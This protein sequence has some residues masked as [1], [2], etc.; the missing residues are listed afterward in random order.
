M[1]EHLDRT[2]SA[3]ADAGIDALILGRAGNARFVSERRGAV[4][5]GDAPVRT[6]LRRGASHRQGAPAQ[7]HRQRDPADDRRT[8]SSIPSRWNP[9]NLAGSVA[10]IPG[11][12]DATHASVST[13]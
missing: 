3:M 8:T 4:A 1:P 5:H 10:A 2:L 11:L 13:A 9:M 6:G 12:A 7:H